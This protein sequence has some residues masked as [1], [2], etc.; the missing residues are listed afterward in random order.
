MRLAEPGCKWAPQRDLLPLQLLLASGG[1]LGAGSPTPATPL[2]VSLLF[3]LPLSLSLPTSL[4]LSSSFSF[5]LSLPLFSPPLLWSVSIS[6]FLGTFVTFQA[7]S[8]RSGETE[9]QPGSS[10]ANLGFEPPA[11]CPKDARIQSAGFILPCKRRCTG[12]LTPGPPCLPHCP[13]M[14]LLSAGLKHVQP[15]LGGVLNCSPDTACQGPERVSRLPRSHRSGQAR[16]RITPLELSLST[17]QNSGT[18]FPAP[19]CELLPHHVFEQLLL[20]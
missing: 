11:L 3:S 10:T 17:S 4:P 12:P 1:H 9:T 6:R 8:F 19:L 14:G 13:Q 2:C 20:F 18:P 5:Y 16:V 15:A 7:L